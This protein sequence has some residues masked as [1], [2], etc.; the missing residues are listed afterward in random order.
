MSNATQSN[1]LGCSASAPQPRAMHTIAE[2]YCGNQGIKVGGL[3]AIQPP[4]KRRS[5]A[6]QNMIADRSSETYVP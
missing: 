1:E 3:K 5:A 6:C 2:H 4:V